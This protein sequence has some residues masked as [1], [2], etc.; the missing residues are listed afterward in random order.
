MDLAIAV[1]HFLSHFPNRRSMIGVENLA[2]LLVDCVSHPSAAHQTFLVSDGEDVSTHQL[3]RRLAEAFGRP[4][5]YLRFPE[6]CLR[7]R[8]RIAG[9]REE[10]DRLL[11]SLAVNSTKVRETFNELLV[12][13]GDGL[14]ATARWYIGSRAQTN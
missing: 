4:G 9:K 1:C 12:S 5:R 2:D 10:A 14:S 8:R 11:G 6:W 13:L 7:V 3:F